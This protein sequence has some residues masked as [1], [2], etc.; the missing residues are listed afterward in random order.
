[1]PTRQATKRLVKKTGPTKRAG[2]ARPARPES[3][4]E[5]LAAVPV[6]KRRALAKLRTQIRAAAPEATE[7]I[8]YGVPT[9]KLAGRLLVSFGAAAA[10]CSLY[11]VSGTD[12][13]GAQLA[14]LESYDTSGKGTV[15]FAADKPLP[16]A[17]VTKLVKARIARLKKASGTTSGVSDVAAPRW[18]R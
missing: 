15:R 17:L 7:G 1:M 8:S 10:H 6:D 5:Y 3:I 14:E 2:A 11:G 16:Q 4:D 12:A 9:F 18:R 13:T